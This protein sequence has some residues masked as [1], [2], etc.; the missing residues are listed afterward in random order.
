MAEDRIPLA[1][2]EH[3]TP[4]A[5]R[6]VG[7]RPAELARMLDVIGVGSLEELAQRVIPASIAS[8][9]PVIDLPAPATEADSL[10]ELR[11]LAERNR[12]MTQ[13]IGLGYH[14]T[15]TPPVIRRNVLENPAWYTAYTPYQPEISQG[16][17]EA[18]LNFQT[19]VADLTG[20][21][22][23]NA[24]MLDEST[25]AAE[26]MT[27]LRR[28][29]KSKS[30][31]FLVDADALPHTIA[32]LETRAEPLGIELVRADL[33]QGLDDLGVDD[34]FGMLLQYPG[35]S[36][37]LRDHETLI[38]QAHARGAM[39]AVAA[40]PLAL[41]LV[42]PP[43]EVGADVVVGSTQ[44]FGVPMGFGGPHAG[45][46]A[47]RKGIE[48][49][50]PGRLVGVS[51]DADGNLAYRLALQTR[52]QHIRR[53]KAT[54]NICTAQ[55]LL[56]VM[57]SMYA[58]YHGPEGLRAIARR[59][60]RMASVLA[61]GLRGSGVPVVHGEF[62][63]TVLVRVPGR[64]AGVLEAA[65][66]LGVNLRSVDDDHVGIACDETTTREHLSLV[67]KAFGVSV[68]DVDGLDADTPDALPSGLRRS[69]DYLTHPVFH[70]HRSET[71]LLRYLRSL[72]DSDVAL[73]RS[74]I[75]LGSCTMKLNATAEME[76]ISW[77]EIADLHPFAPAEDAA[78]LLQIVSD[79]ERWLAQITGYQAVSLQPNAGSQGEFAGLLAIR[80]YHRDR[81]EPARDVCLIPSSAHGTNAASAVMAGMRVIVV[82]CDEQ[83]N[84]DTDH[85][86]QVVDEHRDDL[87]AIMITYPST[88]GVY[89]DTVREV[90]GLV[91]DAGGQVYVDGANLNA[92]IGLAQY[93]KF[94]SDV[95]HLN[96]H[97]TF[98]IPHGGGGP[99]VGPIGV[100]EHLAPF[101]PNHPLQPEA[102][103]STGVGPISGA[104]WGSASILPI[105]WAYVRMMGSDGLRRATLTAVAAANY[106]A[107]RLDEHFPVLYT[108]AD[109]FV[110][111]ECILDLRPIQ[112][113]TGVT[114]DDVAKRLAD[115]G[116]HAPTM[117]FP[118]AGTLMVEPTESEDLAELDRF[119]EAMIAIRREADLVG[120]G[121]WPADDNPLCNA[122]H[123]AAS[124][125][126]EW[127]HPYS[128]EVAVFPLGARQAKIWPPVRRID[129]AKGDRNL[130]CSCPP[131]EAYSGS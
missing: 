116:L 101:L 46:M 131:L 24:S 115:F 114:V 35:A 129:Q 18:L 72:S 86:K 32:V 8:P 61:A 54:S 62:F 89:E 124:L 90:C 48:R 81:G 118:V 14:N 1:A 9:E 30:A 44:R 60:H 50:L 45:Y 22:V 103:P 43:G 127:N 123:T 66:E 2:L 121:D 107:R 5:D 82:R 12:S 11:E 36:G 28:A 104:P 88:H 49:Q 31:R 52:E 79:L 100:R 78:G 41:T 39:V 83:G 93:G 74:M 84:I 56:A 128:R 106:V 69:T 95:S 65:R 91:H 47:V 34:F 38:A 58:V 63:D 19:M 122:P 3:G 6:H 51:T 23:A 80:A 67:W 75:P 73:D 97:K 77:P 70:Q 37:A 27:L 29:G 110:A 85:L 16:R 42:R 108:G 4:F 98:C 21:A 68:S 71:A 113:A 26:A 96:L 130:V 15:V 111:H 64:A 102:G 120:S 53:E 119:C 20:L 57:A 125:T 10:A 99:G 126:G 76:P 112:K 59:A 94:G 87:A 17:L 55:V 92:L 40:D 25:A 105:S 7:P 33:S 109:G 117:S 13:M